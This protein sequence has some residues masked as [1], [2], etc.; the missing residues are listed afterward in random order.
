[1]NVGEWIGSL[2]RSFEQVAERVQLYLPSVLG[3]LGLLLLG[4]LLAGLLQAWSVRFLSLVERRFRHHP[5][6]SATARLGV[7]R[8][9]SDV[10]GSFVFWAVFVIFVGAATDALG[11]PVL[12]TW[13]SGLAQFL[14]RLLLATLIVLAGVLAGA[15][16]RDAISTT[17]K[18]GGLAFGDLLGRLAQVAIIIA[19]TITGVDQIGIDST[20]LTGTLMIGLAAFLGSGALA[21]G[22]GA[23]TVAS[24]IIAVHY[25]RQ[26][27]KTGQQV[28]LGSLEGTI[29]DITST[30]VI[31]DTPAGQVLVPAKEFSE[32][33]STLLS[34]GA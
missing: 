34:E 11:L 10:I 13:L 29:R 33:A 16:A 20:F 22:L 18:A 21:F 4:W 9:A 25:V 31:L 23:R 17:T 8:N 30:A 14:P 6:Q 15:L 3:A 28:R 12:A 32:T 1:M 7:D 2:G 27:Y 24:N 5:L 26:T 19:A